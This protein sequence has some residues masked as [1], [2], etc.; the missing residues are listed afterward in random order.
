[1]MEAIMEV[2]LIPPVSRIASTMNLRMQML[3]PSALKH[4]TYRSCYKYLGEWDGAYVIMDNGMFEEDIPRSHEQVIALASEYKADEIVIPDVRGNFQASLDLM[5]QFL[6]IGG[7][8][9][10]HFNYMAVLQGE[11]LP[12]LITCFKAYLNELEPMVTQGKIVFGLPRR[13]GEDI[14]AHVRVEV[15]DSVR[16][17]YPE[18]KFHFLGLNR[19]W[20]HDFAIAKNYHRGSI[21]SVDTSAPFVWAYHGREMQCAYT[22][23]LTVTDYFAAPGQLFDLTL[24]NRNIDTLKAWANGGQ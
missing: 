5:R 15:V 19:M 9:L 13:L 11:D 3:I 18:A 20:M 22:G 8:D 4:K 6:D 12:E 21:R 2:A 23:N 1:M 16:A 14:G 10:K 7:V 17:M 24:V